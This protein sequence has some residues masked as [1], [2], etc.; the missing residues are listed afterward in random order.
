M[1]LIV[2][3]N[4]NEISVSVEKGGNFIPLENLKIADL[5]I[6]LRNLPE[7]RTYFERQY[8]KLV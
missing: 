3:F 1:K 4:G 6:L 2:T 8:R 7:I 5:Q